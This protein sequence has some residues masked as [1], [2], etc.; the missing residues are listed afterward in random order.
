MLKYIEIMFLVIN[1]LYL[2]IFFYFLFFFQENKNVLI[3]IFFLEIHHFFSLSSFF[4]NASFC[5]GYAEN[6][7]PLHG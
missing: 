4:E 1:F 2:F 5:L 6:H 3:C 7:Y